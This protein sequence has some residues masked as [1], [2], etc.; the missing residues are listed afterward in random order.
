MLH[1]KGCV[2][3]R[4]C[5]WCVCVCLCVSIWFL[6]WLQGHVELIYGSFTFFFLGKIKDRLVFCCLFSLHHPSILNSTA[7]RLQNPICQPVCMSV[8]D[9][10]LS[11]G[12]Q[13]RTWVTWSGRRFENF[14]SDFPKMAFQL[15]GEG[16]TKSY[17]ARQDVLIV[18]LLSAEH[19]GNVNDGVGIFF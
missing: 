8:G 1:W 12:W 7:P 18:C 5:V 11:L 16:A 2:C 17:Y 6:I 15:W 10:K 14:A 19:A 3:A 9:F 13:S 4:V